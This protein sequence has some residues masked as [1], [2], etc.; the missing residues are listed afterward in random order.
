MEARRPLLT[1]CSFTKKN[2]ATES[3]LHSDPWKLI[4]ESVEKNLGAVILRQNKTDRK[5]WELKQYVS[6]FSMLHCC[7]NL[8]GACGIANCIFFRL[9]YFR[10]LFMKEFV[11]QSSLK[12]SYFGSIYVHDLTIKGQI[13]SKRLLVTSDFFKKQT[14][15]FGFFLPNSTKNEFVC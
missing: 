3:V 1:R 14:N 13:I 10:N 4:M 12:I 7:A 15:K 8:F 5:V 9:T 6:Y 11:Q 2:L